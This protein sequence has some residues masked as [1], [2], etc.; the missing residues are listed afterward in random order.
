MFI[1]FINQYLSINGSSFLEDSNL[2]QNPILGFVLN[3]NF[4]YL[5]EKECE[6]LKNLFVGGK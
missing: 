5:T 3:K 6:K 4:R 2:S 1:P